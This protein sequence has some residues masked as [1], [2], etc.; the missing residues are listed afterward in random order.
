MIEEI[1]I[2]NADK[3]FAYAVA[4]FLLVKGYGQDKEYLLAL[5]DLKNEIAKISEKIK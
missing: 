3:G 2:A 1:L 5:R 4:I